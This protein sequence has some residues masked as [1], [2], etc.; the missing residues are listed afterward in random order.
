MIQRSDE[1]EKIPVPL[2]GQGTVFVRPQP[3]IM[4]IGLMIFLSFLRFIRIFRKLALAT[5]LSFTLFEGVRYEH[6][7]VWVRP[8]NENILSRVIWFD[9]DVA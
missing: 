7:P 9:G 8:Y 2:R 1:T 3:D 6:W 5:I 4:L